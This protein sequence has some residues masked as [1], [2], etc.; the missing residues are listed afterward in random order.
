MAMAF[1]TP[2]KTPSTVP[3]GASFLAARPVGRS[4]FIPSPTKVP[5]PT[6]CEQRTLPTP[7]NT[8][9]AHV[10]LNS[11]AA[12][13]AP[14]GAGFLRN[15]WDTPPSKQEQRM[16]KQQ[17]AETNMPSPEK[18]SNTISV[19][20]QQF[21]VPS[22]LHSAPSTSLSKH[23]PA[24]DFSVDL[25]VDMGPAAGICLAHLQLR[26]AAQRNNN[27]RW[28]VIARLEGVGRNRYFHWR[29][30]VITVPCV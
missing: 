26:K 16:R 29:F 8:A 19:P 24:H 17:S 21:L 20:A 9:R 27:W 6:R 3:T 23:L 2:P 7:A 30:C 12:F 11:R 28:C 5:A 4:V 13:A 25:V 15:P 1:D 10:L 22:M 18:H 14:Q